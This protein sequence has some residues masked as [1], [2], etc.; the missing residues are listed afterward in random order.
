LKPSILPSFEAAEAITGVEGETVGSGIY[1]AVDNLAGSKLGNMLGFKSDAQKMEEFE[2]R[3]LVELGN[4]KIAK[5]EKVSPMIAKAMVKSGIPV[6][7]DQIA[8]RPSKQET[9]AQIIEAV[10]RTADQIDRGPVSKASTSI[11]NAPTVV[12]NSTSNTT[13]THKPLRNTEP[14]YVSGMNRKLVF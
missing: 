4:A 10:E 12:N 6:L 13:I 3:S 11:V 7:A 1:T 5:G 8:D 14:S 2:T 9:R